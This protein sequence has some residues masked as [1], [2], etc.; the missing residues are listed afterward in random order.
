MKTILFDFE[1][2][3]GSVSILIYLEVKNEALRILSTSVRQ[4]GFNPNLSGSKKWRNQIIIR[5]S[6]EALCFNPNLSGSKK[7]RAAAEIKIAQ[8]NR[9][10]PN[11]SGSKK[12][13][14]TIWK[15]SKRW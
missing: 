1:I 8:N 4:L 14:V 11:L 13:R 9:F 10:N 12:W 3:W 2:V 7:W 5:E 15:K 6:L